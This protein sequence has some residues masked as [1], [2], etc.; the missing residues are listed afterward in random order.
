MFLATVKIITCGRELMDIPM[1]ALFLGSMARFLNAVVAALI[2]GSWLAS[3][4]AI[5][6]GNPLLF[7]TT[8][9][10]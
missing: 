2:T 7:L 4:S 3:S 6:T 8:L 1:M 10:T 5:M 9:R